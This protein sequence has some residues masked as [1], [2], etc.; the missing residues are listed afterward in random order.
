LLAEALPQIVWITHA[1]GSN[2]YFNQ[3]WVEYTGLTLE[4]GYGDGWSKPFH[5]DDQ[6]RARDA[7]QN[8]VKNNGVYSLECRLR[9]ADGEYRWW[10]VRGVPQ[11]NKG[12]TIE[13]WFG[14]CTDI[15]DLTW[16]QQVEHDLRAAKAEADRAN[17]AKSKFLAAA[18]HDLRQPVQA[19]SLF[20]DV[21]KAQASTPLVTRVVGAMGDSLVGLNRLLTSILDLSRIDAGVV[22]AQIQSID[23]GEIVHRLCTE[24]TDQCGSNGLT[25]RCRCKPGLLALADIT[26]LER[27]LRNLIDNAIRYTVQGGILVSTRQRRDRIRIDVVDTGIGIPADKLDHIFEEFYQVANPAR[28]S[29]QGLG[30]GL[31]IVS[32]LARVI[33]AEV[34][35]QSREGRGTRFT[36]V[37]PAGAASQ[38]KAS[39]SAPAAVVSGLRIM[40][41]EDEPM[42]GMGLQLILEGWNCEVLSAGSGE[43]ALATGEREGWRFD[44]IIADHRLGAG[45]SG[46]QT[47]TEIVRRAGRPIPTL[48]VT[49][50]TAPERIEEVYRSGFEMMHKPV[51]PKELARRLALLLPGR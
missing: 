34:L 14:T 19:L 31:S 29:K 26:L 15:H 1:D 3:K 23:V 10:L 8:A 28:E 18:S 35:V 7:W 41:I 13:R 36:V 24:Y 4:E 16:R 39:L 46:T 49:G 27:I 47:A 2:I 12:G 45:M 20:L 50:D 42:V 44:A 38:Q 11:V 43:E 32:R 21:L 33:G 22:T 51:S 48:I 40:V 6:Q 37:M 5:P 25:M 30:L 17:L 9:R